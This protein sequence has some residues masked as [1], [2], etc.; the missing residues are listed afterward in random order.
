MNCHANVILFLK[1]IWR[2]GTHNFNALILHL[3]IWPW[4]QRRGWKLAYIWC[5]SSFVLESA[6]LQA[7]SRADSRTTGSDE[8]GDVA[9]S[10][11]CQLPD[12]KEL[13]VSAEIVFKGACKPVLDVNQSSL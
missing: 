6:D 4:Q 3:L 1:Q 10:S 12:L 5:H 13:P 8:K 9:S 7:R 11:H 2:P